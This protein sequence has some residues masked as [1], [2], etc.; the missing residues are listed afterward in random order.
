MLIYINF[1]FDFLTSNHS[2]IST[3]FDKYERLHPFI[4]QIV[5]NFRIRVLSDIAT[6]SRYWL[7]FVH[8]RY[9]MF[10]I[11]LSMYRSIVVR[12]VLVFSS[13]EDKR[14]LISELNIMQGIDS[15]ENVVE[16]LGCVTETGTVIIMFFNSRIQLHPNV[17]TYRN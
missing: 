17:I 7:E 16:L 4:S 6:T 15:H 5:Y 1:S 9:A 12:Y 10:V 14:D 8:V 3:I 13:I 11:R 2:Y